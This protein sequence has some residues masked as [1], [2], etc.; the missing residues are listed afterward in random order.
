MA[1]YFSN[2]KADFMKKEI[3]QLYRK[4]SDFKTQL[5]ST[6]WKAKKKNQ[7]LITSNKCAA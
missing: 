6:N 3:P 7:I 4:K 5:R 2:M 1:R